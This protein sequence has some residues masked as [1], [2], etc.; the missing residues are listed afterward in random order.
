[1]ARV[2]Y[3]DPEDL[4]EEDR[5]LLKRPISLHRALANSTGGARAFGGLG[6]W[7][8][9][10]SKLDPRLRE[11]AILQVGWI[12]RSPYEWSHHIKIG[13]DFGVTEDDVRALIADSAGEATDL[14]DLDRLVLAAARQMAEDGA[15]EEDT[16]V[17]LTR[18]LS[19]ELMVELVLVI[20]F[21]CGVVRVLGSLEIDVEP[22]YQPYLDAFPLPAE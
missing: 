19:E 14:S 20:G 11:L 18:H 15:I 16:F 22:D 2:R 9:F 7:I 5:E 4:A 8:R 13:Q 10:K 21:Y 3:L 6:T 12:A 1:M 17:L